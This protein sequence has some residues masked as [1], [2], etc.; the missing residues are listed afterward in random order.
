VKPFAWTA[1]AIATIFIA[2]GLSMVAT[3]Q[4]D[5]RGYHPYGKDCP[6]TYWFNR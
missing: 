1:L 6:T 2:F 3:K 5:C 4:T